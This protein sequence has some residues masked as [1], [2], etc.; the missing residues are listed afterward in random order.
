[1]FKITC[2]LHNNLLRNRKPSPFLPSALENC[3][4]TWVSH[5]SKIRSWVKWVIGNR[6]IALQPSRHATRNKTLKPELNFQLFK[7]LKFVLSY[8]QYGFQITKE[9]WIELNCWEQISMQKVWEALFDL[10]QMCIRR[11][12]PKQSFV[13]WNCVKP[14]GIFIFIWKCKFDIVSISFPSSAFEY[15][16]LIRA[17]N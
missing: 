14:Q 11:S 4:E 5:F 9:T 16:S 15:Q 8:G 3:Q 1:M 10:N 13:F 6:K 17:V 12:S 7:V 2:V